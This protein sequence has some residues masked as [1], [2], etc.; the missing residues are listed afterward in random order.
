MCY[1][2]YY[3]FQIAMDMSQYYKIWLKLNL[4]PGKH[5]ITTFFY[6]L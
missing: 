1:N 2:Y 4:N 6:S 3:D 5:F